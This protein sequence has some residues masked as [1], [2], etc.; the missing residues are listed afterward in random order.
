VGR[1]WQA[2]ICKVT[3]G[4][5]QQCEG[6][7]NVND[8]SYRV[9]TRSDIRSWGRRNTCT[10]CIRKQVIA[11]LLMIRSWW[12]PT[13]MRTVF[14]YII[15]DIGLLELLM[16]RA[17]FLGDS[18]R[19]CFSKFRRRSS[20]VRL[21]VLCIDVCSL[22]AGYSPIPTTMGT[23]DRSSMSTTMQVSAAIYKC[24]EIFSHDRAA[25]DFSYLLIS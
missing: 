15:A 13:S 11:Y 7:T 3:I 14:L 24:K 18:F 16:R 8:S 10:A 5:K 23:T 4:V 25:N 1:T 12:D 9:A 17:W 20:G 6:R 19:T 21:E 2:C 22:V